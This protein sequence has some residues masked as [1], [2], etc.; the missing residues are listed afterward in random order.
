VQELEATSIP[1]V[2]FVLP[3]HFSQREHHRQL[4]EEIHPHVLAV[5]SH[6]AHLDKKHALMAEIGGE[7]VVVHEHNPAISTTR[8][9]AQKQEFA[10]TSNQKG[11]A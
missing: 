5:S 3:E 1:D 7:V 4:L 11:K 9:L 6:T 10:G 2:V 8:S